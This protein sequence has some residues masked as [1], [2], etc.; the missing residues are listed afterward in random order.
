MDRTFTLEEAHL[1]LPTLEPLLRQAIEDKH[2]IEVII[3]EFE[4]V[5][6]HVMA[7]GGCE[8][9]IATLS[10]R[11][12][13]REQALQRLKDTLAEIDAL[14]VQIKD[15]DIGLLDFPCYVDG[16][17]ILLCWRLGEDRIAHW[18]GL[19]E[20]YKGRKPITDKIARAQPPDRPN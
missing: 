5:A 18:H 8:L 7:S 10:R 11:K 6:G 17:T 1:L 2:G 13:E 20:G 3:K 4:Q 16:E 14:G 19:E 9:D 15:L 12:A